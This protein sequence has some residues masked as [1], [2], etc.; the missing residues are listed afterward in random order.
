M[1]NSFTDSKAVYTDWAGERFANVSNYYGKSA[2]KCP[3]RSPTETGST[4]IW[5][6]FGVGERWSAPNFARGN[7]LTPN[8]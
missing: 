7:T 5:Q 6:N 3:L 8:L 1:V 4:P 2:G